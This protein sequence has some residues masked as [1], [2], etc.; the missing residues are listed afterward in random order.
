MFQLNPKEAEFFRS[1]N[2]TSNPGSGGRRYSPYVFTEHGAVMLANVLR[3]L[4]RLDLETG[5]GRR[6]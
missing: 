3:S 1:Q 4:S 6:I 2:A 5:I